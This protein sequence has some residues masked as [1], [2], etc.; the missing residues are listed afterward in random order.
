[1]AEQVEFVPAE[2]GDAAAIGRLRQRIWD[3]TYRGIYPDEV[4]D[5]FDYEWHRERDLRKI[6]DPAFTV[7]LIRYGDEE[8]GYLIFREADGGVWLQSLY[9]LRE[10]QHRGI[11]RQAFSI[12]KDYCRERGLR[13]LACS[14]NPHNENAMRFYQRMGGVAVKTDTGHANR[15]E[16]GVVFEF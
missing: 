13:R 4:I 9:V 12:L 16:D 5:R 6:S 8:I 1:M 15:Q 10:Y 7:Y 2:A 11:G 3:T 14:C